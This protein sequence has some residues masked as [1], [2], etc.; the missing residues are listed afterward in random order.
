MSH[1]AG[2]KN[3]G[4]RIAKIFSKKISNNFVANQDNI[5]LLASD[6]EDNRQDDV[7]EDEGL[8]GSAVGKSLKKIYEESILSKLHKEKFMKENVLF[9]QVSRNRVEFFTD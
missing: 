3:K 8:G 5:D 7:E 6:S 4:F 1:L 2:L 9:K